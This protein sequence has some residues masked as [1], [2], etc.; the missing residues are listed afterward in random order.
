[1]SGWFLVC[2]YNPAGNVQGRFK[3]QVTKSGEGKGG[4]LGLGAAAS[5]RKGLKRVL[6]ALAAGYVLL[7][8]CV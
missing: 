8:V 7:A 2:E 1:M 6:G 4:D 5:E 3:Q